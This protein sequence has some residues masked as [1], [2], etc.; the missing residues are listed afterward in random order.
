[1]PKAP[2]P[3]R[4]EAPG[5]HAKAKKKFIAANEQRAQPGP[6]AQQNSIFGLLFLIG[7]FVLAMAAW[8]MGFHDQYFLPAVVFLVLGVCSAV[9]GYGIWTKKGFMTTCKNIIV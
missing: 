6:G 9:Y 4:V 8:G 5:E 1:M 2:P 7:G 3:T